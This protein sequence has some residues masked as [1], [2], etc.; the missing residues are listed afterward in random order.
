[1]AGICR[2]L[3]H[4]KEHKMKSRRTCHTSARILK[5]AEQAFLKGVKTM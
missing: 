5:E 1:M 4:E 2:P 3:T